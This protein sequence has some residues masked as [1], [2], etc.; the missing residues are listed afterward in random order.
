MPFFCQTI[1]SCTKSFSLD[2]YLQRLKDTQIIQI[3]H[4]D[5]KRLS[6]HKAKFQFLGE[7]DKLFTKLGRCP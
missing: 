1:A 3:R 6:F 5:E 2:I 7:N 4:N